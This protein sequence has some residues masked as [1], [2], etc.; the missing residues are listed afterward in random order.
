MIAD[1]SAGG[2]AKPAEGA[3]GDAET[4][5]FPKGDFRVV[6]IFSRRLWRRR[7]KPSEPYIRLIPMRPCMQPSPEIEAW[8]RRDAT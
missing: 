2:L 5:S 4:R 7:S 8:S 3:G 1:Q 6:R